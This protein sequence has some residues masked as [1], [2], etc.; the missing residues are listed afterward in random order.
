[1]RFDEFV[2]HATYYSSSPLNFHDWP[3]IVQ[4]ADVTVEQSLAFER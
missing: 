4:G 2:T 3:Q 1:M